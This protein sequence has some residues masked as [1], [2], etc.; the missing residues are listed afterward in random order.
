MSLIYG[1]P[2]HDGCFRFFHGTIIVGGLPNMDCYFEHPIRWWIGLT[3]GRLF[4]GLIRTEP[5]RDVREPPEGR[6]EDWRMRAL[7]AECKIEEMRA[8]RLR[9]DKR[10][11]NQRV[12]LRETWQIVEM[13]RKWLGSDTAR[14]MYVNLLKRYRELKAS[15]S[16]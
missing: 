16:P 15:V 3:F 6:L 7:E 8:E 1:R 4:I 5:T 12:A 13:R 10:I 11:H 2:Q 14:K 9:L